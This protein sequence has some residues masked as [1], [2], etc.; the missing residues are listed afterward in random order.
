[1]AQGLNEVISK[2]PSNPNCSGILFWVS[3]SG[4]SRHQREGRIFTPS[5]DLAE[6]AVLALTELLGVV[7]RVGWNQRLSQL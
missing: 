3:L 1:M 2:V 7:H 4:F 6:V 5:L